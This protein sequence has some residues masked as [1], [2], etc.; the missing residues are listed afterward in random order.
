M[1]PEPEPESQSWWKTL[2]GLLTAA[3]A[4][5]T[6]VTG[7]IV[8][9]H[10]TGI[11]DHT[12]QPPA[13]IRTQPTETNPVTQTGDPARTSS[14]STTPTTSQPLTLPPN[15]E[16]HSGQYV[17]RLLSARVDP[18]APG[19][20]SLHLTVRMTNQDRFDANFWA[21]SFRLLV[22]GNLQAPTNNLDELVASHSA[23]ESDVEFVIPA[24]TTTVGL[25]M[26]TVGVDAP[27]ISLDLQSPK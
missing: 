5:I 7:L 22:N 19:Q 20:L 23:K 11:F 8:A 16:I 14:Q 21:A 1:S 17:Y 6:A 26:G 13:Q 15:P 27:A 24:A 25:E 2:P 12:S 3:A 4:I 9:L 18:Y 10:Q